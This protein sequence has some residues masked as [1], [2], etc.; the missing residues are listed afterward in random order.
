MKRSFPQQLKS[1]DSLPKR[2][3]IF[4]AAHERFL[5]TPIIYLPQLHSAPFSSLH[6]ISSRFIQFHSPPLHSISFN[7]PSPIPP[8]AI[9]SAPFRSFQSRSISITPHHITPHHAPFGY[10]LFSDLVFVDLGFRI[11]FAFF[12][13]TAP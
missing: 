11:I 9:I 12:P 7:S 13:L 5:K 10:F 3:K 4:Q 1:P 6:S 8:H 2:P